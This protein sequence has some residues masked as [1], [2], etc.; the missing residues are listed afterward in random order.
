MRLRMSCIWVKLPQWLYTSG[1]GL[2][3]SHLLWCKAQTDLGVVDQ[4]GSEGRGSGAVVNPNPGASLG[5][6]RDG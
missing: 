2:S 6:I 5:Q 4:A 1:I 3:L